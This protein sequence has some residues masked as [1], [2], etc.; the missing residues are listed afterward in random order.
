MI[1]TDTE[2]T[3]VVNQAEDGT[4]WAQV[5]ELPGCFATGDD[6]D[7]LKEAVVEAVSMC[8]PAAELGGQ[9]PEPTPAPPQRWKVGGYPTLTPA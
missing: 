9:A 8:L 4:F 5:K 1:G 7:E 6:L 2:L 3:V